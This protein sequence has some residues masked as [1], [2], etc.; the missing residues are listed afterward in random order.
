M[1][2]KKYYRGSQMNCSGWLLLCFGYDNLMLFP[3]EPDKVKKMINCD[4][5]ILGGDEG[6]ST[7]AESTDVYNNE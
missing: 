2:V 5:S 3:C 1:T 6:S 7:E 4:Q